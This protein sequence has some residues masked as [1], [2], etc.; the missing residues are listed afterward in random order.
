MLYYTQG[1]TVRRADGNRVVRYYSQ[2]LRPSTG[3]WETFDTIFDLETTMERVEKSIKV[4]DQFTWQ[5]VEVA[6]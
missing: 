6:E 2:Y 4:G 5:I 1:A 3:Q